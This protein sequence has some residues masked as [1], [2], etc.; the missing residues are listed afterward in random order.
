[1]SRAGS[2]PDAADIRAFFESRNPTVEQL[3]HARLAISKFRFVTALFQLETRR[4]AEAIKQ[5]K[6]GKGERLHE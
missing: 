3:R 5:A 1:M 4:V 2:S 6:A